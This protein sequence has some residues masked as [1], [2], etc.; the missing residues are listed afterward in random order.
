M[1]LTKENFKVG[2]KVKCVFIHSPFY[3]RAGTVQEILS[4]NFYKI[5]FDNIL[6]LN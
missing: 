3:M 4:E 1:F 2:L 6:Y 5:S